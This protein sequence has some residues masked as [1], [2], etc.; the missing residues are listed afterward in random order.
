MDGCVP[1]AHGG[2]DSESYD[3]A[4]ADILGNNPVLCVSHPH[5][6]CENIFVSKVSNELLKFEATQHWISC[7][8]SHDGQVEPA[9][10][11]VEVAEKERDVEEHHDVTADH[12]G[13]ID[14]DWR[15]ALVTEAPG[16]A[17]EE[18]VPVGL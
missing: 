5:S 4:E 13:E 10:D 3:D 8:D 15:A 1:V 14:T 11:E 2:R 9:L 18:V 12:F 7:Q 17:E 16:G 6:S